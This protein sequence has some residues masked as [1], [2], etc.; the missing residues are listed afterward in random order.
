[1]KQHFAAHKIAFTILLAVAATTIAVAAVVFTPGFNVISA[2]VLARGAVVDRTDV[3]FKVKDGH[4][5]VINAPDAADT[6]VQQIVIG[7][8]G[9]TGWHSHPGPV[10]VV[11]KSGA[12]SFYSAD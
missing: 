6:V 8:E 2:P 1:M 12:L 5:E 3:R 7:P 11:V 9:N 4:M 10:V